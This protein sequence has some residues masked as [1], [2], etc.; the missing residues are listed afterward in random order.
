MIN[1]A[2]IVNQNTTMSDLTDKEISN[3]VYYFA[4]R[5]INLLALS[6]QEYNLKYEVLDTIWESISDMSLNALKRGKGR[7]EMKALRT[8]IRSQEQVQLAPERQSKR[9]FRWNL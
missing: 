1:A 3:Q 4:Q 8:V 7:G 9:K 5:V 2:S 6:A